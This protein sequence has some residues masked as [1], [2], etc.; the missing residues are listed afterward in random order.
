MSTPPAAPP[1]DTPP[2]GPQPRDTPLHAA[3]PPRTPPRSA[4]SR[5]TQPR[6]APPRGT[7]PRNR[8]A[9][10]LAAAAELFYQRGYS[11]V[12]MADIAEAVAISPSALYRHFSG[13]QRLLGEVVLGT[14]S[15]IRLRVEGL[16]GADRGVW[17]PAMAG[18]ALDN[19]RIGVLWRRESRHLEAADR[20]RMHHELA[21]IHDRV[22][23]LTLAARPGVGADSLGP[24]VWFLFAVLLSVSF[25]R[26]RLPRAEFQPL[27]TELAGTVLDID[28]PTLPDARSATQPARS[29]T[30]VVAGRSLPAVT[31]LH[32][33]QD[34]RAHDLPPVQLG[35]ARQ[36]APPR[37]PAPPRGLGAPPRGASARGLAPKSRRE[38]LLLEATRM[39][40]DRGYAEVG[41]DDIGARL[42]MSGAAIYHHFPTKLAMLQTA[43]HRSNEWLWAELTGA[44]GVA[45]DPAD[46]LRRL[47][48]S[49]GSFAV[50][51]A[52]SINLLITE[53]NQLPDD[54]RRRVALSQRAYLDEW[55]HLELG[56][57]PGPDPT[58]AR[59]RVHA[60]LTV[61]NQVARDRR[62]RHHPAVLPALRAIGDALLGL[63]P[64]QPPT[65]D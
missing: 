38:A 42:G 39:F 35:N 61:A 34:F 50:H 44:L 43:F 16:E 19:R 49:Y 51:S 1:R 54:D 64:D 17:L 2:R 23:A 10:I 57:H 62:L 7:R 45:A 5:S 47:V 60:V 21:V 30:P 9:L 15:D 63:P 46:G 11:R 25:H 29:A 53:A 28:L 33:R 59:V 22:A 20:V 55:V 56:V 37:G 3:K 41:I 18:M 24:R 14:L 40:A 12:G 4:P 26:L 36:G 31:E 27:L 32:T 13:K 65:T 58:A 52:D 8:R 6:G 48:R